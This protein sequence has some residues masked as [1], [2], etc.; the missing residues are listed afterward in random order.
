MLIKKLDKPLDAPLKLRIIRPYR[1]G[2]AS[3]NIDTIYIV[4][5][6][7]RSQLDWQLKFKTKL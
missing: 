5:Y 7:I 2:A 3:S 4:G 6:K 1:N